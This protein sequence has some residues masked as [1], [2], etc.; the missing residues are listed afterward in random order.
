MNEA[1]RRGVWGR[2]SLGSG[3][4]GSGDG[5][6]FTAL[7]PLQVT[8]RGAD[9]PSGVRAAPARRGCLPELVHPRGHQREEVCALGSRGV[10]A[11]LH[12]GWEIWGRSFLLFVHSVGTKRP[13]VSSAH[14]WL[15]PLGSGHLLSSK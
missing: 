5:R 12:P 1:R 15:I 4:P 9:S 10:P 6:S 3:V 8:H 14:T 11:T 13:E 7:G 2:G